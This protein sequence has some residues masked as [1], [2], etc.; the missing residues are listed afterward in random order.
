MATLLLAQLLPS[1]LS[2][3]EVI[4][5][6]Y[7][8]FRKQHQLCLLIDLRGCDG[9]PGHQCSLWSRSPIFSLFFCLQQPVCP[10]ST[11]AGSWPVSLCSASVCLLSSGGLS[12]VTSV[13]CCGVLSRQAG[14]ALGHC[15]CDKG[16]SALL[17]QARAHLTVTGSRVGRAPLSLGMEAL[18]VEGSRQ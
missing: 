8:P 10:L 15:C 4:F 2:L 16:W 11:L 3:P 5:R 6:G 14:S 13:S 1:S 17:K 18:G 9:S 12:R 7:L